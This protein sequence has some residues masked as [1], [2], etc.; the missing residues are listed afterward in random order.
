ME[1][2]DKWNKIVEI[3]NKN[4]GSQEQMVQLAWESIFSELF[5]Y[6]RLDG[7]ID[8]QRPVKMGVSTKYPDIIIRIS[9]TLIRYQQLYLKVRFNDESV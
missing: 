8:S 1:L 3:Y 7:D 6:S 5:G 9:F 4:K 2:K